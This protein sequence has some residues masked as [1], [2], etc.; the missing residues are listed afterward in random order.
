MI[1]TRLCLLIVASIALCCGRANAAVGSEANVDAGRPANEATA[2]LPLGSSGYMH[3]QFGVPENEADCD[4]AET[5]V[6]DSMPDRQR[7]MVQGLNELARSNCRSMW[8]SRQHEALLDEMNRQTAA[9]QAKADE[10]RALIPAPAKEDVERASESLKLSQAISAQR[11]AQDACEVRAINILQ[12]RMARGDTAGAQSQQ[13]AIRT[14]SLCGATNWAGVSANSPD[15][16]TQPT[17]LYSAPL[18]PSANQNDPITGVGRFL[19]IGLFVFI[20]L[21]IVGVILRGRMDGPKAAT[22]SENRPEA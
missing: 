14:G 1:A 5:P 17:S 3:Q 22:E 18:S 15:S 10:S 16:T 12:A 4:K 19:I 13:D 2:A 9:I 11:D 6:T 20:V 8:E 7:Q 21:G